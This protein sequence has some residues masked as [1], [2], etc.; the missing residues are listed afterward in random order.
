MLLHPPG[1]LGDCRSSYPTSK[2]AAVLVLLFERAGELRV[3]LTTRSKSLRAHPGQTALPGGKVD[4]TDVDIVA[5]AYREAHEEVGLPLNC[6]HV[7][8]LCLLRPFLSSSKLFVTPVVAFLGDVSVLGGLTANAEEVDCIFDHPLEALLDPIIARKEPLVPIGSEHWPYEVE[9]HS[10]TDTVLSWLNGATYR[11]H[12][13]RSSAS[14]IKG[15]TSEI[16]T[17]TAEIAYARTPTYE[18]FAPG[19][20]KEFSILYRVL[21]DSGL[22]QV[23]MVSS[24]PTSGTVT[25]V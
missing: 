7:Y 11:M 19:Q 15:L 5:T 14:P 17:T 13:F 22:N 6:P 20:I 3:L 23:V 16:L 9:L 2:L 1:P 18:R 8:T 24:A 4:E 10:T 21:Q 12:R 25:P